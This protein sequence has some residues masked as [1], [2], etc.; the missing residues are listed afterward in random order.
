MPQLGPDIGAREEEE[1]DANRTRTPPETV[2]AAKSMAR[3]YP[4]AGG[5][6]KPPAAAQR[7]RCSPPSAHLE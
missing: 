3:A 2:H 5:I 6:S 4:A 1:A 7:E